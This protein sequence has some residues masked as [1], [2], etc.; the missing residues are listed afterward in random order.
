M[1]GKWPLALLVVSIALGLSACGGVSKDDHPVSTSNSAA[2]DSLMGDQD[3]DNPAGGYHD[4][5]DGSIRYYGRAAS[6]SEAQLVGALI[7]RYYAAA[8]SED[9]AAACAL[10]Y[11]IDVETLPELYGQ[12]PGPLWLRGA[13]TCPVLLT[14]V[15]E[16]FHSQLTAPVTVTAV[17]V[18]GVHA[19]ALVGFRTLPAGFVRVRR[20]AGV[21]K[22]DGLL[23]TALP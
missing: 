21:W 20:E 15:F 5:D 13:N 4:S 10:T 18:D 14:R 19:Y 6:A 2:L 1:T 8:A 9:G 17:R 22:V 12:P 7:H 16:H 11:Y 23:A 3:T